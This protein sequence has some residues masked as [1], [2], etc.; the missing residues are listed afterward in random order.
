[1]TTTPRK[2]G[3]PARTE[4]DGGPATR[5]RILEAARTEFAERGYDRTSVRGIAKSAGVDAALVHHYYGTKEQVFA[6]AV[7]EGFAPSLGVPDAVAGG[8]DG[9]GERMARYM[10]SVW[11]N[12]LTRAPLLAV[13]RSALTNETAAGILRRMIERRVLVRVVGELN[14]PDPEFRAQLAAGHLVGIAILRYVVR[15][16]PIASADPE[17]IITMVAPTLQRY[18][19]EP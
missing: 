19:T 12:S 14:V 3:R 9:M 10:F 11:E 7:E 6:A 15:I 17:D 1:M 8:P 16:E 2:R 18:L 5:D 13:V 4:T